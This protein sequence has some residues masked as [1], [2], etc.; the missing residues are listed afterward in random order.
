MCLYPVVTAAFDSFHAGSKKRRE[1]LA[2]AEKVV[3]ADIFGFTRV[4]DAL[5]LKTVLTV[6]E[7]VAGHSYHNGPSVTGAGCSKFI[8]TPK[9]GTVSVLESC[10]VARVAVIF[11]RQ[12]KPSEP[13]VAPD[14]KFR[15]V[16]CPSG[17]TG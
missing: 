16:V 13:V 1:L 17:E 10:T 12:D 15:K 9:L 7:K 8:S 6:W 2:S 11:Q 14:D 5:H 3:A 4:S